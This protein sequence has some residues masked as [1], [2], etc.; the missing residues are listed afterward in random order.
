V[1]VL[2]WLTGVG[3]S[4]TSEELKTPVASATRLKSCWNGRYTRK[5]FNSV[6]SYRGAG[7]WFL[8]SRQSFS[9]SLV[10]G[11]GDETS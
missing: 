8:R 2:V 11:G 6:F 10:S 7:L 3:M 9:I 1:V 4:C 5:F